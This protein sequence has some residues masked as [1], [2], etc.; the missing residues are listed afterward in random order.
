MIA[1]LLP[2]Q[3]GFSPDHGYDRRGQNHADSDH[4]QQHRNVTFH[5]SVIVG[6][7][8]YRGPV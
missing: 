3:L 6:G 8:E 4:P 2:K 5:C 7:S 1:F